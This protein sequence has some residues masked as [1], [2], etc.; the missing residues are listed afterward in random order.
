MIF[1]LMPNKIINSDF[2]SGIEKAA[3]IYDKKNLYSYIIMIE[4]IEKKLSS[5]I[6]IR[7][8]IENLF[9]KIGNYR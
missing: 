2:K 6:N 7:L 1:Q 8:A 3:A 5:G 4:K 9:L